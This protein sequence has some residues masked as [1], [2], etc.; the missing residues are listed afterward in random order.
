MVKKSWLARAIEHPSVG[1]VTIVA[2][3]AAG[4][5][6]FFF[7]QP[8]GV[9]I[10]LL[11]AV[12][13]VMTFARPT[14]VQKVALIVLAGLMFF[15][16]VRS[17]NADREKQRQESADTLSQILGDNRDK[18]AKIIQNNDAKWAAV[19]SDNAQN[20]SATVSGMS[21]ISKDAKRN[22][23]LSQKNLEDVTGGASFAY[24]YPRVMKDR[25]E[26]GIVLNG[27]NILTGVHVEVLDTTTINFIHSSMD[28]GVLSP[29]SF[30]PDN[31]GTK[32]PDIARHF[33]VFISAQN[34]SVIEEIDTGLD[35]TTLRPGAIFRVYRIVGV[36]N[37]YDPKNKEGMKTKPL[38]IHNDMVFAADGDAG[39]R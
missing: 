22:L 11:A 37:I 12:A 14:D 15:L 6:L 35:K 32:L 16:E 30:R 25:I 2:T 9:A 19:M 27:R 13:V 20:F 38:I 24:L 10:G 23:I 33:V 18:T 31:F 1:R 29:T 26:Y 34:G 4:V 17:I 7:P 39:A 8:P 5:W 36:P 28:I 3:T 21:G